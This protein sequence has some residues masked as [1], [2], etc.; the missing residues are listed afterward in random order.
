M[1]VREGPLESH[2]THPEPS[3]TGR[4]MCVMEDSPS[5]GVSEATLEG[6]EQPVPAHGR[7]SGLDGL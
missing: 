4:R 5:R 6:F 1:T 2:P 3:P 7:G